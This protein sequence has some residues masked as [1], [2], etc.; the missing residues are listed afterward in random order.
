MKNG[1]GKHYPV[2]SIG[3]GWHFLHYNVNDHNEKI[4]F[5]LAARVDVD[6]DQHRRC[7]RDRGYPN[8]VIHAEN[9]SHSGQRRAHH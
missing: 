3:N 4:D 2:W 6:L 7:A 5:H 1:N 8:I 9:L